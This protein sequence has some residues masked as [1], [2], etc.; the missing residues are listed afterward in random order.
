MPP[1]TEILFLLEHESGATFNMGIEKLS[2][3]ISK[4]LYI[5]I[6]KDS[7]AKL[8][9][10]TDIE[11]EGW[12]LPIYNLRYAVTQSDINALALQTLMFPNMDSNNIVEKQVEMLSFVMPMNLSEQQIEK[13]MNEV[14]I[15]VRI[16]E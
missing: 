15:M 1:A 4:E 13:I 7:I 11:E 3:P 12:G 16:E 14:E 8:F 6:S 2:E 10:V 9:K 5:A